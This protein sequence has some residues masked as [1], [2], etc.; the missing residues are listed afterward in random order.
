GDFAM[1]VATPFLSRNTPPFVLPSSLPKSPANT[2]PLG[3]KA[4]EVGVDRPDA[5]AVT[6]PPAGAVGRGGP[7]ATALDAP[8]AKAPAMPMAASPRTL[9]IPSL[10]WSGASQTDRGT[11]AGDVPHRGAV[12]TTWFALGPEGCRSATWRGFPP[13][14]E[15][16]HNGLDSHIGGCAR[17]RGSRV[18][19]AR[20]RQDHHRAGEPRPG[21]ADDHRRR[22]RRICPAVDVGSC[23]ELSGA[24]GRWRDHVVDP[25]DQERRAGHRH[26]HLRAAD[27]H[28][29]RRLHRQ[30]AR[31][32]G[33]HEL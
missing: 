23:T 25:L 9:I 2:S 21:P 27:P 10:L 14:V 1:R 12:T 22:P 32:P 5:K 31:S 33:A 15:S 16:R 20:E 19:G 24:R 17:R 6:V 30:R 7:A 13:A 28:R 4:N 11:L 26:L 3:P 29:G 18:P 8:T